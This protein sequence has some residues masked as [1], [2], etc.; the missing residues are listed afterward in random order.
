[1]KYS[2]RPINKEDRIKQL[3]FNLDHRNH[4]VFDEISYWKIK[5]FTEDKV[6]RDFLLPIPKAKVPL[7]PNA[8]ACPIHIIQQQTINDM[9]EESTKFR[10]CHNLSYLPK[11]MPK[12]SIN[13]RHILEEMHL[14]QY[15]FA[16]FQILHFIVP[17]YRKHSTTP[18]LIQKFN[19]DNAFKR[20]TLNL[21]STF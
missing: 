14:I 10:P 20:L 3:L 4:P 17:L 8:E 19:I 9:G 16:L 11:G 6:L 12:L 7:I 5:E 21:V 1:M 13:N 2:L 15:S 18:I